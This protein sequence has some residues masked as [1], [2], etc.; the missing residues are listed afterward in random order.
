MKQ[1]LMVLCI[2][3]MALPITAGQSPSG[4]DTPSA[5]PAAATNT[6]PE[7]INKRESSQAISAA[8]L[9]Q[10]RERIT[11]QEEEIQRLQKSVEE[12]RALLEKALQNGAAAP[13][14]ASAPA[15][16]N[17]VKLVPAVNVA[18]PSLGNAG[19]AGQKVAEN[20][21]P[22]S[23]SIGN[24]TF[25]PLGFVDF[26][27]Y[28]RTTNVGSGIGTSFGGIPYNNSVTGRI[29]ENN[30]STQNSR[31]GFR[32]DSEFLGAKI[33]G[34][35]EADFLGAAPGNVFVTSNSNAFRMRN[36]FVDVQKGSLEVLGGQDWSMFTPN[37]KGLSP[38]PSDI[39]YSQ[40]MDT[41]YQAG[42]IWSRQSQLRFIAHPNDDI[43]FGVSLE[44]P[45]QYVGNGVITFPAA[46]SM[47]AT[48]EFNNTTT[49]YTAPNLHPDIIFKAAFDGHP[50]D[51]LLHFEAGALIRSFKFEN[52]VGTKPTVYSSSSSTAASGEVNANLEI[53]KNVRLIANT[54]FGSG[55]GRYIFGLGPDLIVKPDGSISPVHA[56]STVDGFEANITKNTLISMLY[57]GAYFD[58]DV[59]ID[60][61][62]KPIGY[63]FSGSATNNNRTVQEATFDLVQTFWKNPSYGALS[64]ITQYSYL[65]RNPWSLAPGASRYAKTNMIWVDLRYT[66][67]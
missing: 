5:Q 46:L 67:P 57:G 56:Y 36:F 15:E 19:G 37:R 43:A 34:Y 24:T 55:G 47:A 7:D 64:L 6:T 42:L 12:Q 60:T 50:G 4:G 59:A 63:G 58:R 9:D 20:P 14:L 40:D 2:F 18:H 41:N 66:L 49:T 48:G 53:V 32:V 29:W 28:G 17:P 25:T 26:T 61:T 65:W 44:N 35:V 21:S 13:Q 30:F 38:L 62:G 39:F 52:S 27:W 8:D 45:Q 11:K 3:G 33:L 54:F 51:R 31:I 23:I 1:I 16:S 10:L 22:L